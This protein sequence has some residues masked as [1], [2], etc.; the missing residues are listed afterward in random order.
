MFG[1]LLAFVGLGCLPSEGLP[2]PDPTLLGG[3][4]SALHYGLKGEEVVFARA[5]DLT[6]APLPLTAVNEVETHE[7]RLYPC[8]LSAL[9]LAPGPLPDLA[10][11][12]PKTKRTLLLG[13]AGWRE[14]SGPGP[15]P[16]PRS[17]PQPS[18]CWQFP[19]AQEFPLRAPPDQRAVG[20]FVVPVP[21]GRWLIGARN[22]I[23]WIFTPPADPDA[24][25]ELTPI[26]WSLPTEP[27]LDPVAGFAAPDGRTYLLDLFA[28]LF[29]LD[30]NDEAA[31]AITQLASIP[32]DD[33]LCRVDGERKALEVWALD[34]GPDRLGHLELI[35]A[36]NCGGVFRYSA[37]EDT[38]ATVRPANTVAST[39]DLD[40]AAGV[41]YLGPGEFLLALAEYGYLTRI[42]DG[43]PIREDLGNPLERPLSVS[44][45]RN[46]E[47][48]V[49]THAGYLRGRAES[50]YRDLGQ[51]APGGVVTAVPLGSGWALGTDVPNGGRQ[52]QPVV[53]DATCAEA[54][55]RP[56]AEGP[57]ELRHL[58][59]V[60]PRLL[61]LPWHGARVG[62]GRVI[63]YHPSPPPSAECYGDP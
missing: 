54:N 32:L 51:V 49:G 34:G 23:P 31:P 18:P 5:L 13:D 61:S 43:V 45:G 38:W 42:K 7:L 19:A 4:R 3:A 35:A 39:L 60:G 10:G 26:E 2:W 6:A 14:A 40:D 12:A 29:R 56:S 27:A 9:G 63:V 1:A 48:V 16:W 24:P 57:D 22:T 58:A 21:K 47:V 50:G 11:T 20:T 36:H 8:A 41:L 59:W 52:L 25:I 15:R 30:W 28:R 33:V 37:P 62:D 44:A 53:P 46:G 17:V 55:E